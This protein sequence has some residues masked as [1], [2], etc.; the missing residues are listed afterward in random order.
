MS[1]LAVKKFF[2]KY[3]ILGFLLAVKIVSIHMYETLLLVKIVSTC[4]NSDAW[5]KLSKHLVT[6]WPTQ[7]QR[8]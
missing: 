1:L 2:H 4:V 8:C 6:Y 3:T 7:S 5:S